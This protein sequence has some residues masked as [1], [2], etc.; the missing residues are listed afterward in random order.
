M[1]EGLLKIMVLPTWN[2]QG[3]QLLNCW[4]EDG[5]Y[6]RH[7]PQRP[8]WIYGATARG[9]HDV[10]LSPCEV[11]LPNSARLHQWWGW[12]SPEILPQQVPAAE[13]QGWWRVIFPKPICHSLLLS[14]APNLDPQHDSAQLPLPPIALALVKPFRA[15]LTLRAEFHLFTLSHAGLGRSSTGDTE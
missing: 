12:Y 13:L 14:G 3:S 4:K 15:F 2:K 8:Y 6:G 1:E 5:K 11:L 9:V 7:K 10:L